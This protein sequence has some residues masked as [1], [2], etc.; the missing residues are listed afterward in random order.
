MSDT[1]LA[2]L[3]IISR[4]VRV[5]WVLDNAFLQ[6]ERVCGYARMLGELVQPALDLG[7]SHLSAKILPLIDIERP[8]VSRIAPALEL[9]PFN[10]LL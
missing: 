10:V 2:T 5:I 9:D 4:G 3:E 6:A 1:V 8:A 7:Q